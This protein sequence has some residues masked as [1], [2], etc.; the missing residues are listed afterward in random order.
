MV[1]Q[2]TSLEAYTKLVSD[3]RLGINQKIVLE[4]FEQVK[5][6]YLSNMDVATMLG[7]S[8]NRITPRVKELRK[9]NY[10]MHCG[11]KVQLQT[12][13]KVMLWCK[14]IDFKGW[15]DLKYGGVK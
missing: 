13:K 3:K 2:Q 8:I 1:V 10:L 11:Y 5:G 7:W 9:M 15:I 6:N 4:V 14:P 12:N